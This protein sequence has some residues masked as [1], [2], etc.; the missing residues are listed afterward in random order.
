MYVYS[1]FRV[2]H[3]GH[4]ARYQRH[5]KQYQLVGYAIVCQRFDYRIARNDFAAACGCRVAVVCR[6]YVGGENLAYVGQT[7][8]Q[9][10][11][12]LL[13]LSFQFAACFLVACAA[14]V[15]AGAARIVTRRCGEAQS[16]E[17]LL[18][19]QLVHTFYFYADMIF[20]GLNI[21]RRLSVESGKENCSCQVYYLLKSFCG[22]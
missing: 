19:Q 21:D 13:C 3:F 10:C 6:L 7:R 14:V 17:N 4:H 5:A 12:H 16:G 18:A 11:C 22:G 2:G 1:R 20:Q 15:V 8:Y 9:L